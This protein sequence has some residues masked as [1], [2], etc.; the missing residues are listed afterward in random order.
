LRTIFSVF[1]GDPKYTIR[2]SQ[3][4]RAVVT[5]DA[6]WMRFAALHLDHDGAYGKQ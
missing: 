3:P 5:R 4:Y 2:L 1:Y 6:G